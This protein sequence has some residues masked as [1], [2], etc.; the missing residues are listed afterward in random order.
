MTNFSNVVITD[1]TLN[2]SIIV[3]VKEYENNKP[4]FSGVIGRKMT[5]RLTANNID[6]TLIE[7]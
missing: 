4:L 7:G 5:S 6:F 3:S 1:N 2:K